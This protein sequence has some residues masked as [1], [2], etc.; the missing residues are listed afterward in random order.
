MNAEQWYSHLTHKPSDINEHMPILRSYAERC[1]VIVELGVRYVV[2]TWAFVVAK[3]KKLV[4]VDIKH[5]RHLDDLIMAKEGASRLEQVES[6][7]RDLGIDFE[8]IEHD[9]RTVRLSNH[10]LLFIDTLHNYD[11]LLE[12]LRVQSP[13]TKKYIIMHDT[14]SYGNRDESTGTGRGLNPAIS[15]FLSSTSDWRIKET[16]TNNNG[17]TVLE[18]KEN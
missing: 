6:S 9:S 2:S 17:L 1:D 18:R 14:V 5:P 4:S 12:E 13:L 11:V 16:Y 3:P 8:F 15:E 10:D 7:C